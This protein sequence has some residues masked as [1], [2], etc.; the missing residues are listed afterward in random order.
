VGLPC[1]DGRALPHPDLTSQRLVLFT[2]HGHKDVH[3]FQSSNNT[4]AS[5]S[6]HAV[7]E[8]SV[9]RRQGINYGTTSLQTYFPP[10]PTLH[11]SSPLL[12]SCCPQ[13]PDVLDTRLTSWPV[14]M[15]TSFATCAHSTSVLLSYI[16]ARYGSPVTSSPPHPAS[17][18]SAIFL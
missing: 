9:C 5:L 8:A 12:W 17:S 15:L 10:Y 1:A 16:G 14:L 13:A 7:C 3:F 4:S 11:P 18:H 6:V 2:Q